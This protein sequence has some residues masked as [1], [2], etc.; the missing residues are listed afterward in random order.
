MILSLTS[1]TKACASL[2][3]CDYMAFERSISLA[4]AHLIQS[5]I[6]ECLLMKFDKPTTIAL[7]TSNL[8]KR[9]PLNK[10]IVYIMVQLGMLAAF[11]YR[12]QYDW[13][14][15]HCVIAVWEAIYKQ[16]SQFFRSYRPELTVQNTN[17]AHYTFNQE[18]LICLVDLQDG[19]WS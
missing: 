7:V 6:E 10:H 8:W 13:I 18:G 19:F 11:A 17:L 1:K 16:N 3:M 5:Q 14:E 12:S 4:C 9:M 2:K 15:P